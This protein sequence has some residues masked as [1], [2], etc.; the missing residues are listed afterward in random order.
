MSAWF[1]WLE[2]F[3]FISLWNIKISLKLKEKVL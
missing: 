3:N 1:A 2:M